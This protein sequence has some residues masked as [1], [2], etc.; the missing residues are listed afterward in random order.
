M[1]RKFSIPMLAAVLLAASVV[2]AGEVI[3]RIVALVNGHV[4]LQSHLEDDLCLEAFLSNKPVGPWT[5]QDRSE[6]LGRL[7]DQELL[8]EQ[9]QVAEVPPPPPADVEK[10]IDE[11]RAQ[12]PEAKT[13]TEWKAELAHYGLSEKRL[14][15]RVA[16]QLSVLKQIDLRLRPTV[17]VDNNAIEKYYKEVFLP[18]LH[19]K[20]GADVPLVQVSAQIRE[21]LVQR[22]M[23]EQFNDWIRTL[24]RDSKIRTTLPVDGVAVSGGGLE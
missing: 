13:A 10:R 2:Y 12:Y 5:D 7:I 1:Q 20:G 8:R 6:A 16:Q 4:I 21:I 3:D 14:E 9:E 19:Q 15:E 24:R 18:E 23:G 11:I 22:Q 17:Q